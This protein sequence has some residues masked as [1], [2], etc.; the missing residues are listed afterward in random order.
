MIPFG[1]GKLAGFRL[2]GVENGAAITKVAVDA[3]DKRAVLLTC[4]KEPEGADL[5]VT[6]AVG[7]EPVKGPYPANCGALRDTFEPALSAPD[8]DPALRAR[9]KRWALPARLKLR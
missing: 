1:A 3:K 8:D 4:S 9:M 6:Y 2:D 7:A 5:H